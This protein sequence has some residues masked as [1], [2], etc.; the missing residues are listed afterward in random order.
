MGE[1]LVAYYKAAYGRQERFPRRRLPPP[2]GLILVHRALRFRLLLPRSLVPLRASGYSTGSRAIFAVNPLI[3]SSTSCI[4]T[5][6]FAPG[7]TLI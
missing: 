2:F 6:V 4:P 7:I 1:V 5:G 3:V